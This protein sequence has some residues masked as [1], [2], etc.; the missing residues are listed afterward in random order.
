MRSGQGLDITYGVVWYQIGQG[1]LP[2]GEGKVRIKTTRK[3]TGNHLVFFS[4]DMTWTVL[5]YR[6]TI[7]AVSQGLVESRSAWS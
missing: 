1:S 3:A 4:L 5:F 7:E 6:K 2:G